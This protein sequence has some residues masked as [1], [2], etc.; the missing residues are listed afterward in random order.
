VRMDLFGFVK[1]EKHRVKGTPEY[2][3]WSNMKARCYNPKHKF[4]HNYGGR[5]IKICDRWL[6]SF[7]NFL[8][9]MGH[10]PG[11][12]YSLDRKNNDGNYEPKNCRWATREVQKNKTRRQ[13]AHGIKKM[14]VDS[15]R[16][17]KYDGPQLF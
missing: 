1:Y 7:K 17:F 9:D 13:Q 16:P 2:I 10:K 4:Y 11:S 15:S 8:A 12:D 6:H 14:W 3:A 5:G